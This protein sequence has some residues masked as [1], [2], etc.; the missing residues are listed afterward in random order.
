[1][2]GVDGVDGATDSFLIEGAQVF[3]GHRFLPPGVLLVVD[4]R[5]AAVG[6]RLTPPAGTPVIAAQGGT[7]LPGLVDAH[8][9]VH[10]GALQAALRS[11]VTTELDMFA[12]PA[13]VRSLRRQASSDP[14]MA[15]LRSAGTGAT[16]PGGHPT[17]LVDRGLLAPFPT[18][19]GPRD[20]EAFVADRVA[21][22]SDHLK[23]VLE[24]G[25]TT[26]R[27]CPSLTADTV[28]ALV[29]AAH[30][31]G[32]LVV[33]HA[34]TRAH[35]LLAVDAGVDGLAHLF[36]D[37]PASQEFLDA[38][39]RRDVFVVPTLTSLAARAGR[40]RG[41]ALAADPYL[42]PGIDRGQRALLETDFP[43]G[44]GARA[45]LDIAMSTVGRL[46]RAGVALLAGT[47]ASSPGV[48]H[49]VSLHDELDL[50]V[51]AGLPPAAALAAA[52]SA[53][54]VAF[55]LDDRGTLAPGRRADLVLVD[56]DP[57]HDI[58]RTRA[59]RAVWRNGRR[60]TGPQVASA[61]G[62]A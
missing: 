16:A 50:L 62:P 9:H 10:P 4:G 18:V 40:S 31:R 33:A 5:I 51:Q 47:D 58:T 56:G 3:D 12:D 41:P 59:V 15:D 13:L 7:V 44:P 22:G 34:L 38:A 20:A 35:A 1:M 43:V 14:G 55:R 28:R 23:I 52:T 2:D 60:A 42:G 32:L 54:A 6:T 8:V 39:A 30:A 37:E 46:H 19:A 26:G 48:A 45:D 17:A 11:G 61:A 21:E 53:P 24:D 25:A 27:P 57:G 36:V 49:G 29:L